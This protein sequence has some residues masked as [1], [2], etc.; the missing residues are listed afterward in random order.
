[1]AQKKSISTEKYS[2]ATKARNKQRKQDRHELKMIRDAEGKRRRLMN[3]AKGLGI[4]IER[5]YSI[6]GL[7]NVLR[8]A[9][10]IANS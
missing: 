10:V 9:Q 8:K 4:V 2:N 1:M 7:R 6:G 5:E 3:K